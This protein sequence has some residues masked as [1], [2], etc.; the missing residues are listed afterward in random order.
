MKKKKV[1]VCHLESG[2][3]DPRPVYEVDEEKPQEETSFAHPFTGE[4]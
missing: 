3:C 1:A 2:A 4:A